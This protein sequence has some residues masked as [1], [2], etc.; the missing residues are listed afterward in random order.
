M[1]PVWL[2]S[3]FFMEYLLTEIKIDNVDS[4]FNQSNNVVLFLQSLNECYLNA[5]EIFQRVITVNNRVFILSDSKSHQIIGYLFYCDNEYFEV[6]FKNNPTKCIYNGYALINSAYRQ[7][8]ALK[9]LL[10]YSTNYLKQEINGI[11]SLMFYA[12]T[13]NPIALRSYCNVFNTVR[14]LR[15]G[16]LTDED[17]TI[18]MIL[19]NKLFIETET[20]GHPFTFKTKLPQRYTDTIRQTLNNS[21]I[22][23]VTF[24]KNLNINESNGDRFLFYWTV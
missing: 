16:Q 11:E 1:N 21:N 3:N 17:K 19:K 22:E 9:E 10:I 6:N 4:Y 8:G 18:A 12:V 24:L 20:N 13:S 7:T 15:N 2:R 5:D 14:P 23:E